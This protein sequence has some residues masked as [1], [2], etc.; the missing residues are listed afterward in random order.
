MIQDLGTPK[1]F[2]LALTSIKELRNFDKHF[3][4]TSHMTVEEKT[5]FDKN[6]KNDKEVFRARNLMVLLDYDDEWERFVEIINLAKKA[7]SDNPID[8]NYYFEPT[9]TNLKDHYLYWKDKESKE[10]DNVVPDFF[11]DK[12]ATYFVIMNADNRRNAKYAKE[13]AKESNYGVKF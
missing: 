4:D 7:I 11:L 9:T 2:G 12:L 3:I 13:Y 1:Y 10:K 5:S 6:Q 8:I